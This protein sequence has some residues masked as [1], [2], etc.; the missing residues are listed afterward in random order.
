M[1]LFYQFLHSPY[2]KGKDK[3]SLGQIVAQVSNFVREK[4]EN[5]N[6]IRFGLVLGAGLLLA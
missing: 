4:N 3:W 1:L 5:Y 2:F 6:F